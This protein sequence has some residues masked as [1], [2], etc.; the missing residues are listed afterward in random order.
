MSQP[1]SRIIFFS[2]CFHLR[3]ARF[4]KPSESSTLAIEPA[5]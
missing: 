3:L 2:Q 1:P 5:R 4:P